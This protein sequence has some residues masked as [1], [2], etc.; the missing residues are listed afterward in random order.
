T[1]GF[2]AY[3]RL[4]I[5][6]LFCAVA[7]AAPGDRPF[8]RCSGRLAVGPRSLKDCHRNLPFGRWIEARKI[9]EQAAKS[10]ECKAEM[11]RNFAKPTNLPAC[12][13]TSPLAHLSSISSAEDFFEKVGP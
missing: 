11:F 8:M 7:R 4:I 6:T 10:L 12:P 5:A 1:D 2:C 13:Q 3:S 9:G